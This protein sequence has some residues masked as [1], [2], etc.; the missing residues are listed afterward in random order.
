MP[1][2]SITSIASYVPENCISNEFF[3]K[4]LDTNDEWITQRT[5]IKTRYFASKGEKSSDLG[6]KAAREALKRANLDI[7]DIDLILCASLSPDFFGMPSTACIIASKL[8]RED[9]PAF[10]IVAACTG[11]I[12]LLSVAK[13]YIKSGMYKKILKILLGILNS[14]L[15]YLYTIL[16]RKYAKC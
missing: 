3:A 7:K 16:R 6:V 10:D 5:G 11:F 12:Y 1:N 13:S 4:F 2:A 8:G 9:I 14:F 15:G